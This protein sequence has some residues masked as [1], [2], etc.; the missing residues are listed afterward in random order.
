MLGHPMNVI[1]RTCGQHLQIV[2][3]YP[4]AVLAVLATVFLVL[5]S[6]YLEHNILHATGYLFAVWLGA[7]VT[8]IVVNLRPQAAIGFPIKRPAAK[9]VGVILTCTLLGTVPLVLL[10]SGRWN[11][12]HGLFRLSLLPLWLFTFP[13]VLA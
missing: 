2:R 4:A 6:G 10:G 13:V 8:D 3:S 11:I 12:I 7:F 9:E 5:F 1:A